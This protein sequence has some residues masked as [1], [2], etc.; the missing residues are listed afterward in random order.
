MVRP[1]GV[2]CGLDRPPERRRKRVLSPGLN[3][4]WIVR[5]LST[6]GA[7]LGDLLGARV[8]SSALIRVPDLTTFGRAG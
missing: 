2:C 1:V 4:V 6:S 5:R 3:K 7:V 8:G